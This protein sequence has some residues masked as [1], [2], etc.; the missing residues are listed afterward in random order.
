MKKRILIV[1]DEPD[2]T[3]MLRLSLEAQGY[4]QVQDENDPSAAQ[5][6]AHYFD[7]DLIILDIM[8]PEIDG[9]ELAA[10]FRNDPVLK[11]VPVVF[12]TALID[13]ADAPEGGACARGGQPFLPKNTPLPQVIACIEDK[14]RRAPLVAG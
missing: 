4:Y 8:M 14:L 13:A 12:M 1:D 7:P 10:R 3:M 6:S 2:F 11:D 9:S 5:A